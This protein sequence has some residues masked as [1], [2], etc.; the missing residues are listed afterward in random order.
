MMSS[1]IFNE[2][3]MTPLFIL[4]TIYGREMYSSMEKKLQWNEL[5]KFRAEVLPY[6]IITIYLE[7]SDILM[8]CAQPFTGRLFFLDEGASI[9]FRSKEY[10]TSIYDNT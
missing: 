5:F 6:S 9:F 8:Q 7:D 3:Q 1:Y 4:S 10:T 2:P